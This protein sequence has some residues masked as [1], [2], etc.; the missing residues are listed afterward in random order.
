MNTK[1]SR[2]VIKE[3]QKRLKQDYKT[4]IAMLPVPPKLRGNYEAGFA[5]G[6]NTG[7]YN[8]LHLLE[9]EIDE[10]ASTD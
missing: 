1:I 7:I 3:L 6:L 2:K 4:Q 10:N 8:I 5:D 9:V